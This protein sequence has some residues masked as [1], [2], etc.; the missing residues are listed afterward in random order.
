MAQK[1]GVQDGDEWEDDNQW[2]SDDAWKDEEDQDPESTDPRD[3]ARFD[4]ATIECP[5]C[6][7]E[8]YADAFRCPHCGTMITDEEKTGSHKKAK[9]FILTA[10]VCV[11][12][13]VLWVL[14]RRGYF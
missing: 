10:V 11:L 9:W 2:S 12:M 7:E 8:V 13:V 6:G 4:R 3:I 5:D 14:G 1:N